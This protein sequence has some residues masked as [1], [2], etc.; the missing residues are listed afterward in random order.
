MHLCTQIV[1]TTQH[2]LCISYKQYPS[3]MRLGLRSTVVFAVL[4]HNLKELVACLFAVASVEKVLQ[5]H[6]AL[7]SA[8]HIHLL[9]F[10]ATGACVCVCAC[11]YYN[12][13]CTSLHGNLA[14]TQPSQQTPWHWALWLRAWWYP[15]APAA[16]WEPLP[17]P[18]LAVIEWGHAVCECV[19]LCV[20]ACMCM[21]VHACICF[22]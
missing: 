10:C 22:A 7:E 21:C 17:T 15:R 14:L 4:S 18:P 9:L 11:V 5:R 6:R 1:S 19:F 12:N 16:L 3:D 13:M 8:D 20:C 2:A